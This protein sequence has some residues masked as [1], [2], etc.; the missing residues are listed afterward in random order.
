MTS[1][2]ELVIY[3]FNN[4]TKKW[5]TSQN[6]NIKLQSS[7]YISVK[8]GSKCYAII[9][10]PV[11]IDPFKH[12]VQL[13][14]NNQELKFFKVGIVK[15]CEQ[16]TNSNLYRIQINDILEFLTHIRLTSEIKGIF[17]SG[18][19][20]RNP[21]QTTRQYRTLS[22]ILDIILKKWCKDLQSDAEIYDPYVTLIPTEAV[23]KSN[24]WGTSVFIPNTQNYYP[25]LMFSDI[26]V[27]DACKKVICDTANLTMWIDIDLTKTS[28]VKL[29]YGY[30]R[31]P[32]V[33]EPKEFFVENKVIDPSLVGPP[34]QA[35]KLLS[36]N[37]EIFGYA[38]IYNND[39]KNSFEMSSTVRTIAIYRVDG[40][41]SQQELN[42]LSARMLYERNHQENTGYQ[43]TFPEVIP[44]FKEGDYFDG[45]GDSTIDPPMNY[46]SGNDVDPATDPRD[47]VWKITEIEVKNN[48]M[49]VT[50]NSTYKTI[51]EMFQSKIQE[52]KS[53]NPPIESTDHKSGIIQLQK[54]MNNDIF[55]YDP[56]YID[57]SCTGDITFDITLNDAIQETVGKS[58]NEGRFVEYATQSHCI[59]ILPSMM[60]TISLYHLDNIPAKYQYGEIDIE[61]TFD[62]MENC[63]NDCL[64]GCERIYGSVFKTREEVA[65]LKFYLTSAIYCTIGKHNSYVD[66]EACVAACGSDTV[67]QSTNC[68]DGGPVTTCAEWIEAL[69]EDCNLTFDRA[70]NSLDIIES[71][72]ATLKNKTKHCLDR[73]EDLNE[74]ASD[75]VKVYDEFATKYIEDLKWNSYQYCH[76]EDCASS[77]LDAQNCFATYTNVKNDAQTLQTK[78]TQYLTTATDAITPCSS[79][80]PTHCFECEYL[81]FVH[82][83]IKYIYTVYSSYYNELIN[84]V[85][86]FGTSITALSSSC[87]NCK[88]AE[89]TCIAQC[90]SECSSCLGNC[91]EFSGYEECLENATTQAQ[92]AACLDMYSKYKQ[93]LCECSDCSDSCTDYCEFMCKDFEYYECLKPL[94]I[95]NGQLNVNYLKIKE[96]YA[97]II[98]HITSR[99]HA[100]HER[101]KFRHETVYKPMYDEL[102][103]IINILIPNLRNKINEARACASNPQN[104]CSGYKTPLDNLIEELYNR[105]GLLYANLI[106]SCSNSCDADCEEFDLGVNS[107]FKPDPNQFPTWYKEDVV[108]MNLVENS[109]SNLYFKSV[110]N[111]TTRTQTIKI[112]SW[113]GAPPVV[114]NGMLPPMN[115]DVNFV[116]NKR[117]SSM[118]LNNVTVICRFHYLDDTPFLSN[119]RE[120]SELYI[121]DTFDTTYEPATNG[122][123][124]YAYVSGI[125]TSDIIKVYGYY[126]SDFTELGNKGY[127]DVIPMQLV[128][129]YNTVKIYKSL[130]GINSQDHDYYTQNKTDRRYHAR[131]LTPRAIVEDPKLY[132]IN[133]I[134][135][136]NINAPDTKIEIKLTPTNRIDGINEEELAS[137]AS[138]IRYFNDVQPLENLTATFER[139]YLNPIYLET[140]NRTYKNNVTVIPKGFDESDFIRYA[141]IYIND[142]ETPLDIYNGGNITF[143]ENLV[144]STDGVRCSDVFEFGTKR[145]NIINVYVGKRY[146][147]EMNITYNKFK[148]IYPYGEYDSAT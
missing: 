82:D 107:S 99:L 35:I 30:T 135:L 63:G 50:V 38:D 44:R 26:S 46:K 67:C 103:Y 39:I 17:R 70:L 48:T 49:Y 24:T 23:D 29:E 72:F 95:C 116:N 147:L 117:Y 42:A 126:L 41:F 53:S 18:N 54:G 80:N 4:N 139:K 142:Y 55:K 31:D 140:L 93:C 12:L 16:K 125:K 22:E 123:P 124:L 83:E 98:Q 75:I 28:P 43:L 91:S 52:V 32:I 9:E 5:T 122:Y 27:I 6:D 66:C 79:T 37:D 40:N 76:L 88:N 78:L 59:E 134:P 61:Y 132:N 128:Q 120:Y 108:S 136:G 86:A 106:D 65:T 77:V 71:K 57:A 2:W 145:P 114:S 33:F 69:Y 74:D 47:S 94:S 15:T 25:T 148:N 118:L 104:D 130:W 19:M 127:Q 13:R 105:I 3:K 34:V 115:I 97:N 131:I 121:G 137:A 102:N 84:G 112:R 143:T 64:D 21:D 56:L 14:Y 73:F 11:K 36:N 85:N 1:E 10:S 146:D 60:H 113:P 92:R 110:E 89:N 111:F 101:V 119:K 138:K 141:K 90:T 87:N 62:C 109:E 133:V 45:L 144:N 58:E 100:S 7:P 68:F 129:D 81:N 8:S 20:I 96:A 51:F